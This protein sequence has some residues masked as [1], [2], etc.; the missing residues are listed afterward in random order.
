MHYVALVHMHADSHPQ[1]H[2]FALLKVHVWHIATTL[3]LKILV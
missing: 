1:S 3:L 2:V